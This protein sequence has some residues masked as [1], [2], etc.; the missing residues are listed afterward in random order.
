M[1][2]LPI[3]INSVIIELLK[4]FP[5][6][7]AEKISIVSITPELTGLHIIFKYGSSLQR[8]GKTFTY[9]TLAEATKEF[10]KK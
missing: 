4:Q 10:S 9:S 6:Y 3:S 1:A 5:E 7:S 8:L 2:I